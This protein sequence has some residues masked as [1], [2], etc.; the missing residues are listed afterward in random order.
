[1]LCGHCR[2]CWEFTK[3]N[4]MDIHAQAAVYTLL[5]LHSSNGIKAEATPNTEM[6]LL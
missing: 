2:L 4:N 3:V 6:T 1:M 5:I